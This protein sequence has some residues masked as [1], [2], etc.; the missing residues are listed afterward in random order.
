M[1]IIRSQLF[2]L[3]NLFYS[4]VTEKMHCLRCSFYAHFT[5]NTVQFKFSSEYNSLQRANFEDLARPQY[6]LNDLIFF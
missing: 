4:I 2:S 6:Q 1:K 3:I 5:L